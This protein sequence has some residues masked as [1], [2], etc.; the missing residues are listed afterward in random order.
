MFS[1]GINGQKSMLCYNMK[2]RQP[3]FVDYMLSSHFLLLK[4]MAL[5]SL[6]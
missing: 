4:K 6:A 5:M 1:T 3:D 2:T